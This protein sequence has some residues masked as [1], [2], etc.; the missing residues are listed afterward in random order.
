MNGRQLSV[1]AIAS[2]AFLVSAGCKR[3]SFA[4]PPSY[5]PLGPA[6]VFADGASAR[7]LVTGVVPRPAE[8]SPGLPY[9]TVE[10]PGPAQMEK[11]ASTKTIP[12]AVTD[13]VLA[14]GQERFD[15]YC[16]ACHGRTGD[17]NGIVVQRGF[18]H[19]PSFYSQMLLDAPDSHIYDVISN[20]K[21][22]MFS[23]DDR[24]APDDRWAIV[25]YVR[26]L[27][28]SVRQAAPTSRPSS[29]EATSG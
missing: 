3:A 11:S 29:Y 17:G 4:D 27:Q 8:D 12:F 28:L 18:T 9:V 24:I 15:I 21:G 13:A 10:S 20:G 6:D 14:R 22:A 2:G 19:P 7:P 1:I 5:R 25:A 26:S 23:Y 16:V